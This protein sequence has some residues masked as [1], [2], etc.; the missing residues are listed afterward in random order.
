MNVADWLEMAD[1]SLG[2]DAC[3]P[4]KGGIGTDGYATRWFAGIGNL[5]LARVALEHRLGRPIA[6]GMFALHTCDNRACIN[7]AH[8]REG[9]ARDNAQERTA[10]RRTR[11]AYL[12]HTLGPQVVAWTNDGRVMYALGQGGPAA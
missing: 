9:T 1:Q 11:N 8:V 2:P 6:P 4:T 3:W 10:R 5:R 7:P 12:K